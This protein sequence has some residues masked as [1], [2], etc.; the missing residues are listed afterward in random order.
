[1]GIARA[2]AIWNENQS[3]PSIAGI[4]VLDSIFFLFLLNNRQGNPFPLNVKDKKKREM[5]NYPA[6]ERG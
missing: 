3:C 5:S 4:Q 1:M 6:D 2:R